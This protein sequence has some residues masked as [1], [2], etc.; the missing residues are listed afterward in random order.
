MP[1]RC[2]SS[3][4][5]NH[6]FS[7]L[8]NFVR[9]TSGQTRIGFPDSNPS[10]FSWTGRDEEGEGRSTPPSCPDGPLVLRE[11]YTFRDTGTNPEDGFFRLLD[12]STDLRLPVRFPLLSTG[13]SSDGR[14]STTLVS[15]TLTKGTWC[16]TRIHVPIYNPRR[17]VPGGPVVI[18]G[19]LSSCLPNHPK[20]L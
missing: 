9:P 20:D 13:P 3:L 16:G 10:L 5:N 19:R 17:V 12:L 14:G 4:T 18:L 11:C 1:H 2:S 7:S 15:F 6:R 8:T